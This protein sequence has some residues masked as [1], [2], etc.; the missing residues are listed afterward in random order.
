[1]RE[2]MRGKRARKLAF[3]SLSGE[4]ADWGSL[5]PACLSDPCPCIAGVLCLTRVV[6][7]ILC[8]DAE[9]GG[10]TREG[11]GEED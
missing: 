4:L 3:L 1:M 2:N 8:F 5:R 11:D 10:G 7:G 9:R 6:G